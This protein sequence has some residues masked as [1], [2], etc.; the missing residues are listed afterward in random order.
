MTVDLEQFR[1]PSSLQCDLLV[2]EHLRKMW[3]TVAKKTSRSQPAERLLPVDRGSLTHKS[4]RCTLL[5]HRVCCREILY[6]A[7][8]RH[9]MEKVPLILAICNEGSTGK[10]WISRTKE[11]YVGLRYFLC[12][13]PEINKQKNWWAPSQFAG[14]LRRAMLML[15]YITVM[16]H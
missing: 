3:M 6:M 1:Q 13:S 16:V 5:K 10:R 12:C 7:W 2:D 9:D 11:Q 15:C 14:Y 4:G 8:C